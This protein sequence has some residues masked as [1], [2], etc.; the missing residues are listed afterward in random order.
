MAKQTILQINSSGRK[1]GSLTRQLS[2]LVVNQLTKHYSVEQVVQRDLATG[3]PFID[4]QWIGANF[5]APEDRAQDHLDVLALSDSLVKELQHADHIVIASP[6]Y[7]FSVPAVLKAWIDLVARAR[8]TFQYTENGPQGLLTGKKAYL[9]M[10][11]GGVPIGSEMDFATRYLQQ[12]M[13]FIGIDDVI[14]ID[15]AKIDLNS[16]DATNSAQQQVAELML[17]ET[18]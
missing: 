7:N 11:S 10:A 16:S 14:V 5:T 17:A 15:A 3:L 12:V 4:E 1:Q 6:V 2:E 18:A 9:V 13:R 8:L